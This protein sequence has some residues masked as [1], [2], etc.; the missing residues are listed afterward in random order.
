MGRLLSFVIS[1]SCICLTSGMA[2]GAE[3]FDPM[4]SGLKMLWGLLIVLAILLVISFFLKKNLRTFQRHDKG[5]IRI[6]ETKHVMPKKTLMLVEVRG[7]EFLVGSGNDSINIIVPISGN[8]S[9]SSILQE[10]EDR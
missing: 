10:T 9:F 4:K 5:L 6:L 2:Y 8:G 3:D 1:T 7:K